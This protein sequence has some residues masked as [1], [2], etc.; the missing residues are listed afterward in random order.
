MTKAQYDITFSD[1]FIARN[2]NTF[3]NLLIDDKD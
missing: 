2:K 1:M 3:L